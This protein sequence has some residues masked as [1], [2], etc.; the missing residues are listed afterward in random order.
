[1]NNYYILIKLFKDFIQKEISF[2]ELEKLFS[3]YFVD[4]DYEFSYKQWCI[5]EEVNDDIGHTLYT[6]E[7]EDELMTHDELRQNLIKYIKLLE[8]RKRIDVRLFHIPFNFFSSCVNCKHLTPET[9][10]EEPV[11]EAARYL[12]YDRKYPK[13]TVP[14]CK[15]FPK[16]IPEEI[17]YNATVEH[18][19]PY[20]N[21][22]GINFET[23]ENPL[24]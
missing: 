10:P 7:V 20:E 17:Y 8:N 16:G 1:M 21:D 18:K 19:Q 13:N 6:G 23:I 5:L 2:E 9:L 14:T 24:F 4:S 22:K 12:P 11:W 15:A 3:V